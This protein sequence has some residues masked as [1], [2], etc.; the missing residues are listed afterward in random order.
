MAKK[1][2]T[3]KSAP[4][5]SAPKKQQTQAAMKS[6]TYLKVINKSNYQQK[7]LNM[8]GFERYSRIFKKQNIL[9]PFKT[10]GLKR[11]SLPELKLDFKKYVSKK[12]TESIQNKDYESTDLKSLKKLPNFRKWTVKLIYELKKELER[13]KI[14]KID[15]DKFDIKNLLN[16]Y[17]GRIIVKEIVGD[18]SENKRKMEDQEFIIS[19]NDLFKINESFKFLK[20]KKPKIAKRIA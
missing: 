20:L 9:N 14:H 16:N 8:I 4:S 1:S 2:S 5:K 18:I 19:E 15:K 7:V 11:D 12:I 13:S 17:Y 3:Y 6:N 10:E